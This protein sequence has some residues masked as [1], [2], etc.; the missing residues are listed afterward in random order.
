M[1]N[2]SNV[3]K[4]KEHTKKLYLTWKDI[5]KVVDYFLNSKRKFIN[6]Y[7]IPR[8][9]YIPAVMLSHKLNIPMI[10]KTSE[11]TKDTV[12]VDDISDSGNT[13]KKLYDGLKVDF[14]SFTIA[15]KTQS[16]IIPDFTYFIVRNNE[17]VYFPWEE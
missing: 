7:G 5:E 4:T 8:G 10:T 3:K 6:I 9:G 1:D 2:I 16:L 11:I 17:W 14:Y 15:T 13:L 12:V